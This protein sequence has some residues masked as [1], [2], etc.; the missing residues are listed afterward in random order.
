MTGNG[1]SIDNTIQ[2]DALYRPT[3]AAFG[4]AFNAADVD[5][6]HWGSLTIEFDDDLSG[7]VSFSSV[8][9]DYGSGEL[10]ISRLARPMLADCVGVD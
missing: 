3:G 4:E 5:L 9:P 7:T 6:N 8:D 2:I 10:P 1:R